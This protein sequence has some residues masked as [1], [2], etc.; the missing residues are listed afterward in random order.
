MNSGS[1]HPSSA[2]GSWPGTLWPRQDAG[3]WS[4]WFGASQQRCV[5]ARSTGRSPPCTPLPRA[6]SKA[7]EGID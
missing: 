6:K 3:T 5:S 7:H 1:R 4:K 2:V